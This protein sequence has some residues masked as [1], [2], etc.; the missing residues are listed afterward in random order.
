MRTS[1]D[2]SPAVSS[3]EGDVLDYDLG[4]GGSDTDI[5]SEEFADAL[6]TG[7]GGSDDEAGDDEAGE[8]DERQSRKEDGP[9]S[10]SQTE[11]VASLETTGQTSKPPKKTRRAK[12][13]QYRAFFRSEESLRD[14]RET[15]RI[16]NDVLIDLIPM[17]DEERIRPKPTEAIFPLA[18]ICIAGISFPLPYFVRE[19][20]SSLGLTTN[21]ITVNSYRILFGLAELQKRHRVEFYVHDL[22]EVYFFGQ[23]ALSRKYYLSYRGGKDGPLITDLPDKDR[24]ADDVVLVRGNWEFPAGEKHRLHRVPR[25]GGSPGT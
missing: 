15:Y 17:E 24:Y 19:V 3:D 10:A 9:S 5:N 11:A 2:S 16:P 6:L 21:Q 4:A 20:L 18:G 12:S 8:T 13:N 14:F 7:T 23:N 22:L 1:A 25:P